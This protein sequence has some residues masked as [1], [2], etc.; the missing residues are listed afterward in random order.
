[1]RQ[2]P[3][4]S[5]HVFQFPYLAHKIVG[6]MGTGTRPPTK[7]VDFPGSARRH[8]KDAE[9]LEAANRLANA[10]HLYGYVAECGLKALLTWHGHPTDADG[11]PRRNS[12][13]RVH[14]DDLVIATTFASLK[15]L[16]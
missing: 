15:F 2:V 16:V 11:S 10:G 5:I 6:P 1:M 9:L 3:Q 8:L 7:P 13:F 14:V 4:T 12:G